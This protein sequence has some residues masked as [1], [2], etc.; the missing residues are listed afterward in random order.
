GFRL[1]G[2]AALD[3]FFYLAIIGV[4]NLLVMYVVTNIAAVRHLGPREGIRGV[5]L[6]LLGSAIAAYVL[7]R[8]VWPVPPAPFDVLPYIVASWLA[9]GV[10]VALLF[11]RSR[12]EPTPTSEPER[13]VVET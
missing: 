8:N 13:A 5:A 6:P 12:T 7:Y 1:E 3:V 10:V 9:I 2:T 4:L 11:P